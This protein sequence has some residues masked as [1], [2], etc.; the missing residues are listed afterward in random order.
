MTMQRGPSA[1][2]PH[3]AIEL[4]E[5][6]PSF[7]LFAHIISA[8]ARMG[9][10]AHSREMCDAIQLDTSITARFIGV[11]NAA[12]Y[13]AH[14]R[15]CSVEQAVLRLGQFR[16]QSLLIAIILKQR[17]NP[18]LC[19]TFDARRYWLDAMLVAHCSV[20]VARALHRDDQ[21]QHCFT[22]GL[23]HSIGL[24]LLVVQA[25]TE[26]SLIL[27]QNEKTAAIRQMCGVDQY[28][29]GSRLLSHWGV[30]DDL[31]I[32]I[33]QLSG[34]PDHPDARTLFLTKALVDHWYH[35]E[36]LH[37]Q[38]TGLA[39][40]VQLKAWC[41]ETFRELLDTVSLLVG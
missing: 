37:G 23:L 30:P 18:R 14:D 9:A 31:V 32:P 29:L 4:V 26:M 35:G 41:D 40:N 5:T 17:F 39:L 36:R 15:L 19:A 12:Y 6:L 38:A 20:H 1:I 2:T 16:V 7:H 22:A 10:A 24:L 21:P 8:F 28:A 13:A 25:P 33:A 34:A 11:A 27:S 3:T